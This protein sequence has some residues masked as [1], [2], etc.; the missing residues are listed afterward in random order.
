MRDIA[1]GGTERAA[2][3]ELSRARGRARQEEAR[4]VCGCD[5]QDNERTGSEQQDDRAQVADE[6][7]SERHDYAG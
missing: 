4:D 2:Y 1:I 6:R 5:E 3:G 7:V